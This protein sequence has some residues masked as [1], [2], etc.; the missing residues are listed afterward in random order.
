MT[1][2]NNMHASDADD[3]HDDEK[4]EACSDGC[5]AKRTKPMPKPWQN[6]QVLTAAASGILLA[7]GFVGS[8]LGLPATI[9]TGLYV[10][11]VAVGGYYFA[12]EAL[13]EIVKEREVGIELLMTVAAIAS[14]LLGEWSEAATLV[15][16]YAIS[17]ASE[18]Y[19]AE[20]TRHAIRALMDLA[21]K[22]ALLRRGDR[23]ER[24]PV[25]ALKPGDVFVVRPGEAVPT[26]GEVLEGR[27]AV[28]QAPVTGESAPV[29]KAP[30]DTVFAASINGEGVLAVRATKAFAENT[31][32]RI[33]QLVEAA[34]AKKGKSQRFIER[35]GRRYS[36]AVLGVAVLLAVV[37]MALGL[38]AAAWLH[39]AV[40]F[41]VAAAPCALVISVPI[42]LVAAIGTAG[43]R[44]ILIKGGVHLE[45]LAKVR[46]VALDKTG[47][48]TVGRPAVTEVVPFE[49]YDE[50]QLLAEAVALE[51]RSQHPLARAVLARAK[52]A[53]IEAAPA[54]DFQSMTGLG[55][56]G[57]VRGR[58]LYI[59]SPK[60]FGELGTPLG[61]APP[62]VER[63]Q[64]EGNTVVLFGTK[65][66]LHGLVAIADPL[67]REAAEAVAALKRVGIT[68]V[69]M[70]TGDNARA[71]NA[72][73]AKAGVDEVFADLSPEGKTR[74][75][76]ELRERYGEV[77]MVGDGVNDAPAL[78]EASV[79]IAMGAA[80]T[81]VALETADVAL[82][83]DDLSR[84]P[85]LMSFS[86]RTWGVIRQNLALSIVVIA[87][88]SLGAIGGFFT[89]PVAVLAHEVSELLV[90]SN[91]L[92]M[93]RS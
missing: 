82:M 20:R 9:A 8:K 86:H 43:R 56:Q 53:G 90:I 36:P 61:A 23:E 41:L 13:E 14:G 45:E 2:N 75:V 92:R 11:A 72:I 58:R 79:G 3:D 76:A 30:A 26:D 93:L 87:V 46:V 32:S 42:T 39:R 10:T 54:E 5:H 71:A 6:P 88:L 4:G 74:R 1:D 57:T 29:E 34:Q 17:E 19:T 15:F 69:V 60:L 25:E 52:A 67:R 31:I 62:H 85:Y 48:L 51:A 70:L 91:G 63:L 18:G 38:G 77:A 81:D 28:N 55:A 65:E 47:T 50:G 64:A 27:S 33:I 83:T 37:P 66:A 12:R 59:G 49:G 7:V 78:A 16:L 84:L 35:F 24:V 40:V 21:P 89:L 44:G 68:R 80:G 22:T 73:G